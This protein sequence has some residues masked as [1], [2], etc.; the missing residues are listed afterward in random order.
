MSFNKYSDSDEIKSDL[1]DKFDDILVTLKSSIWGEILKKCSQMHSLST[2][3]DI[4]APFDCVQKHRS[5]RNRAPSLP[6]L[7]LHKFPGGYADSV[8]MG[9]PTSTLPHSL[10]LRDCQ[11]GGSAHI[12]QDKR[13][14]E[15]CSNSPCRS[16]L[17][18]INDHIPIR[19][20]STPC[21]GTSAVQQY[22][23]VLRS[24]LSRSLY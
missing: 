11:S 1:A 23:R 17:P 10:M 24:P 13:I 3:V 21:C 15:Q 19:T 9:P 5:L 18:R 7:E 12:S 14:N 8:N 16:S 22:L 2:I 6:L 20:P 4:I